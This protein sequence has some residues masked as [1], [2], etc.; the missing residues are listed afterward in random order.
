M[1]VGW[2]WGASCRIIAGAGPWV[3]RSL[4]S[5]RG[6]HGTDISKW[7]I[8]DGPRRSG[9]THYSSDDRL[10]GACCLQG[11]EMAPGVQA[12]TARHP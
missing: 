6:P 2:L 1:G 12:P 4:P 9:G 10:P 7:P 3:P 5:A 11:V 8:L